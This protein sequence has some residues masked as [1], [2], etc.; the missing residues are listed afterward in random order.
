MPKEVKCQ[1]LKPCDSAH[2]VSEDSMFSDLLSHFSQL[3][4][5]DIAVLYS[6]PP[7]LA[8]STWTAQTM[9]VF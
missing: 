7:V 4:T 9:L 1:I 2:T 3:K 8:D 5:D 6:P